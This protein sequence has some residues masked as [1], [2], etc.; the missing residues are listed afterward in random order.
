MTP[1]T[2]DERP[3]VADYPAPAA[4]P[5][6]RILE[7]NMVRLQRRLVLAVTII[8]FAGFL[9]AVW[10]LWGTGLTMVDASLFLF[11]YVF[12]GL[13]I[14]V[15][16]HRYLTHGGFETKPWLRATFA[17][18][19]SMAIQGSV[20]AWVSDH[21]RHHAFSDRPGDPHS[22]HLDEGPGVRGVLKGLWHAHMGWLFKEE[23]TAPQRWAPDLWKDPTMRW[24]DKYF[25]VWVVLSFT[26]PPIAGFALTGTA[27]GAVTAFLWA[28]LARIFLLH[29]VTWSIN[30][31]C[32]F[33]GNRPYRTTDHS[34]NN[35]MLSLISFGESWH[36]NHHAFPT[37]AVHGIER[38]QIDPSGGFI[39]MLQ[40]LRLVRDVKVVSPKQLAAKRTP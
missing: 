10:S 21:R 20:I 1:T 26:L 19:G 36:N 15:G 12:T 9:A 8:P 35:W 27:R 13:G 25:P 16:F 14:T 39:R 31:I 5:G 23:L 33:Y 37:S 18:A 34:T 40:K 30:S 2:L 28:T 24:I 7:P 6:V 38:G 22:P 11:F 17:I 3:L 4:T 29:H 32:H